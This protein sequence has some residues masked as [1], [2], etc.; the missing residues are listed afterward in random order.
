[1]DG[2]G[3]AAGHEGQK[4]GECK[5]LCPHWCPWAW[6]WDPSKARLDV[7]AV[8]LRFKTES[9]GDCGN[10]GHGLDNGIGRPVLTGAAVTD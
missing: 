4:E 3:A 10:P 2:K 5:H 6:R 9:H 7:A 1:M 8:G